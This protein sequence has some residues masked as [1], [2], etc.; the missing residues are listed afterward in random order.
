LDSQEKLHNLQITFLQNQHQQ[1]LMKLEK[2]YQIEKQTNEKQM[3]I[4]QRHF[5]N[6]HA[7][8]AQQYRS[9][10]ILKKKKKC[11]GHQ[12]GIRTS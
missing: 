2:I 11:E 1:Q 7:L 3:L 4:H 12:F 9:M 5:K 8:Q 10:I 6:I